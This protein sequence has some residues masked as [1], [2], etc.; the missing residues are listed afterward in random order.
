M[1]RA[2]AAR[3]DARAAEGLFEALHGTLSVACAERGAGCGQPAELA[4][5]RDRAAPVHA[6][7]HGRDANR[8]VLARGSPRS[9]A[10]A[11]RF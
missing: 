3:A 1:G 11:Q 8:D 9:A 5:P 6:L 7:R 10:R 4:V 2:A